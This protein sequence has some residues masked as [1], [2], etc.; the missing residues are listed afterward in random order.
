MS[1]DVNLLKSALGEE[2]ADIGFLNGIL[3]NPFTCEWLKLDFYVKDGIIVGLADNEES[4]SGLGN[5]GEDENKSGAG[6]G[7]AEDKGADNSESGYSAEKYIDLKGMRVIPG[8]IDSHVHIESSLLTPFEYGR[9]VIP[10]G[11]TAV[12]ADPHEIANV[13]GIE[14][15]N[16]MIHDSEK[17]PL[18]LYYM[19]P[20]CVPATPMDKAG[21]E[22]D[23]EALKELSASKSIIGLG[24]MMNF[25]GVIF[26]DAEV[27]KKLGIFDI[28]D[29]HSPQLSGKEL[30]AYISQG[31]ESDH[32]CTR[33]EEALEKLRKG[34]YIYLREGSTEKNLAELAGIVN[35]HNSHRCS[36]CT[37]DRHADMLYNDGHIDDCIRKAISAGILP[38]TAIK[39]ATLS[40]A[41]RFGLKDR[42]ALSPGRRADFCTLADSEEFRVQDTYIAG[43]KFSGSQREEKVSFNSVFNA[44]ILTED[45][46]NI[47][48]RG[49]ARIIGI[50]SGQI[51]TDLIV[52]EIDSS[53]IPD[54]DRDIIKAVVCNRYRAAGCGVGLINGLRIREGA[55][56]ASISHD[57]HNIVAA[58]ASDAD[59]VRAVNLVRD[60]SGG[61]A[62]VCGDESFILPLDI[63]GIMS[64]GSYTEV[65]EGLKKL[66]EI[67]E[68]T[69]SVKDPLYHIHN[70]R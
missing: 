63:G 43:V 17:T 24:E 3:F 52:E 53:T 42:G 27:Q 1:P 66:E 40:P 57:S 54:I 46:L 68:K 55:V 20:G 15:I 19:A 22:L 58:G 51:I 9:L 69:G 62:A 29:G 48:G 16:F 59:I 21:A 64:S 18:A 25:P 70:V 34:M 41:E 56:C 6:S 47:S 65:I 30:N 4:G 39:M 14:G 23:Y 36:L 11:T 8:L 60:S 32:E 37:D 2:K 13:A 28:I 7:S 61:M 49:N 12:I 26:G 67:T 38:E 44:G 45:D 5:T 10:H 35:C 50:N 31:I 33:K